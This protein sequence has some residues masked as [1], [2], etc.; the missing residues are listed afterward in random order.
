MVVVAFGDEVVA[1]GEVEAEEE[2]EVGVTVTVP[3]K[4]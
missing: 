1:G 3:K 4:E 2:E